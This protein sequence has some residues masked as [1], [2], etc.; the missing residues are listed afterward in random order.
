MAP[1]IPCTRPS[2]N[3]I[4]LLQRLHDR[5]EQ[6]PRQY[7]RN[8]IANLLLSR[9]DPPCPSK[10]VIKRERLQTR[11]LTNGE[12]TIPARMVIVSALARE[13]LRLRVSVVGCFGTPSD[14]CVVIVIWCVS[15]E[16]GDHV[17]DSH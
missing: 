2:Q 5:P 3:P 15:G 8:R 17:V 6:R 12:S 13:S 14:W 4:R 11:Q 9:R 7:R 10:G 16:I 1:Q